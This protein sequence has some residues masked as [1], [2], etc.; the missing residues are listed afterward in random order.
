MAETSEAASL[1]IKRFSRTRAV[2]ALLIYSTLHSVV[3]TME[4]L[5]IH[6]V[7]TLESSSQFQF[8]FINS[9]GEIKISAFKKCDYAAL[10]EYANNDSLDR[11]HTVMYI[12]FTFV[13]TSQ[14]FETVLNKATQ[15]YVA[16]MIVD[17]VKHFYLT[18][19]NKLPIFTYNGMRN[20]IFRKLH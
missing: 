20:D 17:Y 16:K 8:V 14:D 12:L 1:Q 13:Q 19:M 4:M 3:L 7:L 18:K 6:V 15:L 5:I 10:F 2:I 11:V 9:F